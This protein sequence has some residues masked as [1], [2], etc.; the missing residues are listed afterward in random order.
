MKTFKTFYAS[1]AFICL[2]LV[3]ISAMG[4]SMPH[5]FTANSAARA[6]EMNANFTYL[7]ERF[8]GIR[9]TTVN[10][11]NS[12]TGS[13]IN[14]A[15][16]NGYNSIVING[17]CKENI[18]LDGSEENIPRLLKLRG[19]NND[20]SQDKIID[21]SSY[22][23][24]VLTFSH[25]GGLLV[26][27]DNL[28]ISGG[29]RGITT[30]MNVNLLIRNSKVE[31]YKNRGITLQGNSVMQG[32]NLTID[33]SYSG[34]TTEEQGLRMWG[35]AVAY[36]AENL[37]ITNNQNY[38]LYIKSLSLFSSS[39]N[40]TLT[41]NGR[42]IDVDRAS[43]LSHSNITISGSTD[44]AINVAQGL[45]KSNNTTITNT[46]GN[47]FNSWMS[48]IYIKNLTATG[49]GSTDK[50]LMEFNKSVGSLYSL[51]IS[52]SGGDGLQ[53][54]NSDIAIDNLTS[55]NN[56]G[57][58]L[59][60]DMSRIE[61]KNSVISGNEDDGIDIGN[62][63]SL[64]VK[65]S[66]I[67]SNLDD[68]IAVRTGSYANIRDSTTISNNADDGIKV[69]EGSILEIENSTITGKAGEK[70]IIGYNNS[71][72][73]L[74]ESSSGTTL[75]STTNANAIYLINSFGEIRDGVTV[76]SD[77]TGI[78]LSM[79]SSLR[80]VEGATVNGAISGGWRSTIDIENASTISSPI[81]CDSGTQTIL[82]IDNATSQGKTIG[83]TCI[84]IAR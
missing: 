22:T 19:A 18:K 13:G 8:S 74:T 49:D 82:I 84:K 4:Q 60:A 34:A 33:G 11:G 58:G 68:G 24:H 28:T 15:I 52:N 78:G 30:W 42:A 27:I 44:K 76:T 66:T 32:E 25:A 6:S 79:N 50:A 3:P 21:N 69:S 51:S 26:T 65:S 53:F 59:N 72:L 48:N 2:G 54:Y 23:E 20:A 12:G 70:A 64:S 80:I 56:K 7:L 37:T 43:F 57:N 14:T 9:E 31:G 75:I 35:G 83:N 47:N 10:C 55:S 1:F 5:T 73:T 81:W 36:I 39:A 63:S 46:P 29:D 45:F 77:T 38:G 40:I 16:Q 61:I 41:G 17:I 71:T 62:G 67:S